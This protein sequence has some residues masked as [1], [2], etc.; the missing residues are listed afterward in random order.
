MPRTLPRSLAP[1]VE[2][3]ELDQLHLIT[4]PMLRELA[5]RHHIGSPPNVV[6]ARLRALGWLLDTGTRGVWEFA[7]AAHAGPIGRGDPL[8]PLRTALTADPGLPAALAMS[9]AAWA[10]GY[11]DRVPGRLDVALSPGAR[12]PAA[13]ARATHVT[14]FAANL[15]PTTVRGLPTH[16]PATILAHLATTPTA[17][18]S[19]D[20]TTEW[21]PD[22]AADLD[23][24]DLNAELTGRPT[25]ARVRAG[26]LI[27]GLR[28]DLATPLRA[29][30]GDVVRFGPRDAQPLRHSSA[31][32]VLDSLLPSDPT[33]WEPVAP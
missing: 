17:V 21:L 2:D 27:S 11:A 15:L 20:S 19:W 13:L 31:W 23:A 25:A 30:V 24:D 8:L 5:A 29:E 22:L 9:A 33:T 10:H 32:R 28:P 7:P 12:V 1:V 16:R 4:M 26:Y 6:A 18:R 14:P 3:L